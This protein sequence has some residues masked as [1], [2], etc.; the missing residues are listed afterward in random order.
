M[1]FLSTSPAPPGQR[2]I[3]VG[4]IGAGDG[5]TDAVKDVRVMGGDGV[6][7]GGRTL[8]SGGKGRKNIFIQ[9]LLDLLRN[10]FT[11]MHLYV[12]VFVCVV[13][14]F[15]S[16]KRPKDPPPPRHTPT[17]P[18]IHKQVCT[19]IFLRLV[20]NFFSVASHCNVPKLIHQMSFLKSLTSEMMLGRS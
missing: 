18:H 20:H 17:H 1:S 9:N 14:V 11:F 4:R 3:V 2:R 10:S 16:C 8:K 12:H 15:R 19:F 6:G 7:D 5:R 13:K